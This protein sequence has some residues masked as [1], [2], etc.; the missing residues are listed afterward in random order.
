M[1]KIDTD[2]MM[3]SAMSATQNL[4]AAKAEKL[5]NQELKSKE[6]VNK[7]AGEFEALLLHQMM[8][9]MW[10]TVEFNGFMGGDSNEAQIY[11][12][13]MSQAIS[14][15]AAEGRGIGVKE[16]LSKELFKLDTA[17]KE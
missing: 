14:E 9:E 1:T 6:A 3:H 11:R 8:K 12:D 15:S 16:F 7:A 17:S 10:K 4:D 13:M 2:I 5:K